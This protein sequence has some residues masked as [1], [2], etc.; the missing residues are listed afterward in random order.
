M[1][2]KKL[3]KI[4]PEFP[5][6]RADLTRQPPSLANRGDIHDLDPSR[7]EHSAMEAAIDTARQLGRPVRITVTHP[8]AR[9]TKHIVTA[10]GDIIDL[11]S[12]AATPA[13]GR[14]TPVR[15]SRSLLPNLPKPV[16]IGAAVFIVLVIVGGIF[17][18]M[19]IT[20]GKD[21][22]ASPPQGPGPAAPAGE[23][24]AVPPPPGF[25]PH[26]AWE[27]PIAEDTV[28]DVNSDG[29]VAAITP[30]DRSIT[31]DPT[32]HEDILPRYLTFLNPEGQAEWSAP[33]PEKTKPEVGPVFTRIDGTAVIAAAWNNS[34]S[35]W[36]LNGAAPTTVEMPRSSKIHFTGSA[37]LITDGKTQASTIVAG[38]VTPITIPHLTTPMAAQEGQIISV[39]STG[40]WWTSSPSANP[41]PISPA[42]PEGATSVANVVRIIDDRIITLWN[43]PSD[44]PNRDVGRNVIVAV[45]NL[46]DGSI[47][48]ARGIDGA[49]IKAGDDVAASPTAIAFGPLIF[50]FG[51]GDPQIQEVPDFSPLSITATAAYGDRGRDLVVHTGETAALPANTALPWATS[52]SRVIVAA[53]S[54][55]YAL[56]PQEAANTEEGDQ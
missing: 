15:A 35:Y 54:T 27:I 25:S 36:P 37:P 11:S 7:P 23:L 3:D 52:G 39:E 20:A 46:N 2:P 13:P 1:N 31:G 49:K 26:A 48:A 50:R 33:L 55:I 29:A 19:S 9:K 51:D 42:I 18:V 41:V 4:T 53:D 44:D 40:T 22:Q 34:L 12:G 21:K 32:K 43:T 24:Y 28:I 14:T 10:D 56:D 8:P 6:L 47:L 16:L 17:T 45:H 5:V 30:N 38:K